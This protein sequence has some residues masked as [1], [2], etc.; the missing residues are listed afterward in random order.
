[1]TSTSQC[2]GKKCIFESGYVYILRVFFD[3]CTWQRGA[4]DS[5]DGTAGS[6]T[7]QHQSG[8]ALF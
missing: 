5:E 7:D 1:M 8:K 6:R 4:E 2:L 3:Q